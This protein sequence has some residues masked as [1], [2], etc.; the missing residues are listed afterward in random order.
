MT[1]I[2]DPNLLIGKAYDKETYHCYTFLEEV[3]GVPNLE[4]I[5]V[6]LAKEDVARHLS[7][8]IELKEPSPYCI[9]LLGESHIGVYY[10]NG[11]YHNDTEGVR[12]EPLRSLKLRYKGVKYYDVC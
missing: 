1:L 9:A 11:C 3:I 5:S 4:D 10:E 7:K 8:F 12:Y 6:D 2:K